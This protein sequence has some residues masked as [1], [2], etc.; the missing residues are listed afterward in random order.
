M[1]GCGKNQWPRNAEVS[2]QHFPLFAEKFL[3]TVF[4]CKIYIFQRQTHHSAAHT[5][6]FHQRDKACG[7]SNHLVACLFGKFIAVSGTA[8]LLVGKPA[9]GNHHLVGVQNL[10]AG[11]FY[12]GH[13]IAVKNKTC[14]VIIYDFSFA[15]IFFKSL[16]NLPRIVGHRENSPAP[17]GFKANAQIFKE[18]HCCR[19]RKT[20]YGRV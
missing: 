15:G 2:K 10:T 17:F 12:S 11:Q 19:R 6:V 18:C 9:G 3:L 7:R 16:L 8:C 20:V 1:T 5:A 13:T 4:D 14:G